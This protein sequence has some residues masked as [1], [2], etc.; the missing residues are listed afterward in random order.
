MRLHDLRLFILILEIIIFL[1]TFI[2]IALYTRKN[3]RKGSENPR[4]SD[5][6]RSRSCRRRKGSDRRS[7]LTSSQRLLYHRHPADHSL[8]HDIKHH[9]E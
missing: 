2:P 6:H 5:R 8:V 1:S 7:N 9:P 3:N 4:P